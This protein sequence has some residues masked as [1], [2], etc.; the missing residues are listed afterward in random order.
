MW[1]QWRSYA[2]DRWAQWHRQ[3]YQLVG[4]DGAVAV[5][6][7]V[8][9]SETQMSDLPAAAAAMASASH[10]HP[11][12]PDDDQLDA[13]ADADAQ[14]SGPWQVNEA[15]DPLTNTRRA[16]ALW[17]TCAR[18]CTRRCVAVSVAL[19][20]LLLPVAAS[21]ALWVLRT[22]ARSSVQNHQTAG[23]CWAL[24]RADQ[25]EAWIPQPQSASSHFPGRRSAPPT[26]T[27]VQQLLR[28]ALNLSPSPST[29]EEFV[30]FMS[31]G[32]GMW[33]ACP[34]GK[35]MRIERAEYTSACGVHM[36][37]DGPEDQ[38]D[39]DGRTRTSAPSPFDPAE[40]R[41]TWRNAIA[42]DSPSLDSIAQ[43]AQRLHPGLTPEEPPA[44]ASAS[45][46]ACSTG[47]HTVLWRATC[48]GARACCVNPVE[49]MPD[50]CW[51]RLKHIRVA[52]S[53]HDDWFAYSAL[54]RF[55]E[56]KPNPKRPE[57]H[58]RVGQPYWFQQR[59]R[60][61]PAF[62][63]WL[64]DVDDALYR[65]EKS[66]LAPPAR[67]NKKNVGTPSPPPDAALPL[68]PP[69]PPPPSS[70]SD[71]SAVI[72]SPPRRC[73]LT[74]ALYGWH[75]RGNG[76]GMNN[77]LFGLG[78]LLAMGVHSGCDV[79]VDGYLTDYNGAASVPLGQVIDLPALNRIIQRTV[80][81]LDAAQVDLGGRLPWPY[82]RA[83]QRAPRVLQTSELDADLFQT[84]LRD[85]ILV[86]RCSAMADWL[87]STE[88]PLLDAYAAMSLLVREHPN[89]GVLFMGNAWGGWALTGN[90]RP[91]SSLLL[92]KL[93]DAFA[94]PFHQLVH[95]LQ[96][97]VVGGSDGG[98]GG[99]GGA[100]VG[101]EGSIPPY[102]ALH[103]R[104]EDDMGVFAAMGGITLDAILERQWDALTR[105][106]DA[107]FQAKPPP[108]SDAAPASAPAPAPVPGRL[109]DLSSR[110]VY[111]ATGVWYDH[112]YMRRFRERYPTL[113]VRTKDQLLARICNSTSQTHQPPSPATAAAAAGPAWPTGLDALEADVAAL[114]RRLPWTDGVGFCDILQAGAP[115]RPNRELHAVVDYL[116][117]RGSA[118]Y[119]GWGGSTFSATLRDDIDAAH[120][121][122]IEPDPHDDTGRMRR[123]GTQQVIMW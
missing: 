94:P 105:V 53:C 84:P 78:A 121:T 37:G 66:S 44:F 42:R 117:A 60:E 15:D 107:L 39:G 62:Q 93:P 63:R 106:T 96:Q 56:Q 31:P 95:A 9:D 38:G 48:D 51:G 49:P 23:T 118:L 123:A 86:G 77:Q 1:R 35:H 74:T 41:R 5:A 2:A 112:P 59:Q 43:A 116:M 70:S 29:A 55:T 40:V 19:L 102:V 33:L 85:P 6:V 90:T 108:D 10:R 89:P 20:V 34:P 122:W 27:A 99:G 120:R 54:L 57:L 52:W 72:A 7:T 11:A 16:S 91:L 81:A 21:V 32:R 110:I 114:Y 79:A 12:A 18:V 3:A 111:M 75:G 36:D 68:P 71:N 101:V 80:A 103:F 69:P 98:G 100:G 28:V 109:P 8:A 115:V 64:M 25:P 113:R 92:K 13:D 65:F 47:D 83:G 26:P 97:W 46:P 50:P 61:V 76:C 24:P 17:S 22:L 58:T 87:T 14:L 82:S 104:F 45:A 4:A 30:Q 88:A 67:T 119:L 73:V